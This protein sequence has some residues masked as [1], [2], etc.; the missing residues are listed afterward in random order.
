MFCSISFY[1]VKK[2]L[3]VKMCKGPTFGSTCMSMGK[4]RSGSMF[5]TVLLTYRS[6]FAC[7]QTVFKQDIEHAMCKLAI[8]LYG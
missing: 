2:G 1:G 6:F 5:T 8:V 4:E 7:I 3:Y